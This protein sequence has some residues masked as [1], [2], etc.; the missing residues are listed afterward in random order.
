M[1]HPDDVQHQP[2][3]L[4]AE[5][6]ARLEPHAEEGYLVSL[7]LTLTTR[8]LRDEALAQVAPEDFANVAYGGLW[9]TAQR[10]QAEGKTINARS[11]AAAADTHGENAQRTLARFVG[12]VPDPA[13]YPHS[14]AEVRRCSGLRKVVQATERINQ[15]V[16]SAV[17]GSEALASAHDELAKLDNGT[18]KQA[19]H[20]E[21]FRDLLTRL[22]TELR[23]PEDF[24][25]IPLPWPELNDRV[26]GGLHA[27]RM[28]VIGARPGEGKSIAAHQAAEH[29]ASLRHPALV[30]SVEMGGVEVAGRIVANGASIEMSEI[31]RRDLST[32]SWRQFEEYRA[33]AQDYPLVINDRPDLTLGYITAT[34][35]AVKRQTGLDVVVI[36][37][38]QLLKSE[39]NLPREQ[40]VAHVSRSLKQLSRELDCAVVVPAQLNRNSVARGKA[41]LSDLRESGGIEADADVVMLLAREV[42]ERGEPTGYLNINLA[43]N[44]HGRVGDIDLQWRPHYSRIG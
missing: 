16:M 33:R 39:R 42:T 43:K 24:R 21:T 23:N 27:G 11:L 17:D 41:M 3:N 31:S 12:I 26:S 36:D 7:L 5:A 15:R 35:R 32:S 19:R 25:I 22:D 37:Y 1:T 18:G 38:L 28:Y 40:Q 14:I 34:C 2:A 10:L 6:R 8:H 20:S 4:A 44:R 30:F 29:A 13:D 9:G